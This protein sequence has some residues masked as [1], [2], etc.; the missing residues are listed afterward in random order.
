[1]TEKERLEKIATQYEKIVQKLQNRAAKEVQLLYPRLRDD[2][3]LLIDSMQY[4]DPAIM[5][6]MLNSLQN[7]FSNDL[8]SVVYKL[9]D[10]AQ[11]VAYRKYMSELLVIMNFDLDKESFNKAL[12]LYRKNVP[13]K[14][15]KRY[16]SKRIWEINSKN[17]KLLKKELK[18]GLY[19]GLPAS[20]L[21]EKLEQFL[22]SPLPVG[23]GIYRS[24]EANTIR[25][26]RTE[27]KRAYQH[28]EHEQMKQLPFVKGVR[29]HLSKAHPEPDMCD[30]L[31]GVYP[32][33]FVFGGWHP[34]CICY[35]TFERCSKEAVSYTHLTLPTKRIV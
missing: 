8:K 23:A 10:E 33:D 12:N 2:L 20:E 3:V 14:V 4:S 7:Q 31:A 17:F 21:A 22:I 29:V 30:E 11:T 25:L 26:A 1:M 18:K 32:P 28:K 15:D 9:I 16:I 5:V 35:T 6:Q 13:V 19:K 34:N 24:A 27:I